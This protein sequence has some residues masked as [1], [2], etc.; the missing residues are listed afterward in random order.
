M[1]LIAGASRAEAGEKL[2]Y[3]CSKAEAK[4]F[5]DWN[6]TTR[7]WRDLPDFA[8]VMA[9]YQECREAYE[10]WR[11]DYLKNGDYAVE[12]IKSHP[13][14]QAIQ[15]CHDLQLAHEWWEGCVWD[16][17]TRTFR[18]AKG[19]IHTFEEVVEINHGFRCKSAADF[20]RLTCYGRPDWRS[21]G[22]KAA[23]RA[24]V[25]EFAEGRAKYVEKKNREKAAL[26][27]EDAASPF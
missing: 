14:R 18:S 12:A 4:N 5:F 26:R 11:S 13:Q 24:L 27:A 9:K 25:A 15:Q 8:A 23:D 19:K 3:G 20:K 7:M 16:R 17:W 22:Q 21:G 2:M 1:G 10:P 6:W